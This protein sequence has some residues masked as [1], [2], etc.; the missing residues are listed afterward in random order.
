MTV[1]RRPR[2]RA[3][4]LVELLVVIGIIAV[5]IAILLPMLASAR[6][7]SNMVKCASNLRQI[8]TGCLL[9]AQD[10]KGYMPLAGEITLGLDARS[11]SRFNVGVNDTARTR[12]TYARARGYND[13]VFVPLPGAIAPYLGWK[14]LDLSDW[15]RMDQQL[16]EKEGVWKI[17][18]C[19]S[20]DSYDKARA[21][22]NNPNDNT[23]VGQGTF[24]TVRIDR[25]D[26]LLAWSTNTDYIFNEGVFGF[27]WS[28]V[29]KVA[30]FAGNTSKIRNPSSTMLATDGIPRPQ[31][32]IRGFPDGWALW[33]P[34]L[35]PTESISLGM[36]L[37]PPSSFPPVSDAQS[38]DRRRHRERINV[39]FADGHVSS[40]QITERDL[41]SVYL[42]V[43]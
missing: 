12:Y 30:R 40:Y 41:S 10:S 43:K 11:G 27:H 9:R 24:I 18:I 26:P 4:T 6:R 37:R 17:L 39:V 5:L 22:Q 29:R 42:L 2:P 16:N 36:A 20:T 33:T 13:A 21:N 38:F 14:N 31:K 3:F 7:Q 34:T 15:D 32:P 19:P 25:Y 23:P 35:A 1:H 8:A 28:P